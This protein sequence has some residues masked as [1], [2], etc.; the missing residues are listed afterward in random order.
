[1]EKKLKIDLNTTVA[2]LMKAYPEVIPVFIRH[3]MMCV[4][5]DMSTFETVQDAARNYGMDSDRF[6]TDLLEVLS[7]G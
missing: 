7:C 1:M 4:G 6:L 3:N 2:E 5:C